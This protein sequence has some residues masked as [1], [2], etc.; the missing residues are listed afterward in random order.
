MILIADFNINPRLLVNLF[1]KLL[2]VPL[3]TGETDG[4]ERVELTRPLRKKRL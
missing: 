2:L 1:L 4:H 3:G